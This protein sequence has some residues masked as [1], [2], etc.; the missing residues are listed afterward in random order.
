MPDKEFNKTKEKLIT[1]LEV[2]ELIKKPARQLSLGQRM[3]CEFIMA[4]LH[5]PV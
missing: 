5:S 4:M 2:E 1:L 3:K